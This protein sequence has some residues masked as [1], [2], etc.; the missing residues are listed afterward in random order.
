MRLAIVSKL[1]AKPG[2]RDD[3]LGVLAPFARA[4]LDEPGTE[5]FGLHAGEEPDV[6]WSYEVFANDDAFVAHRDGDAT[7]A[8]VTGLADVLAGPPEII[9]GTPLAP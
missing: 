5:V 3:L 9:R 6:V 7:K 1:T 2:R 8:V 4:S